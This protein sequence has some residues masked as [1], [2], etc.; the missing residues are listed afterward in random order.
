MTPLDVLSTIRQAGGRVVV[1]DGDLRVVAPPGTLTPEA[2]VVLR[3]H[4]PALI[5][6]LPDAEREA[7]QWVEGLSP[8]AAV[9]VEAARREWAAIVS[10][11][12]FGG[13]MTR[14]LVSQDQEWS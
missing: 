3:E 13:T 2:V 7:I 11:S 14:H 12:P 6:I 10:S 5:G 9:V 1:L 8:A 4:K